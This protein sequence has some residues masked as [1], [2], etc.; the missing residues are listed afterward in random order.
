MKFIY[1]LLSKI[2]LS[3]DIGSVICALCGKGIAS[4]NAIAEI[5]DNETYTFDGS[6]CALIFK[7]YRT[8]YG[9]LFED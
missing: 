7:K 2:I 5:V 4:K 6:D 8:V 3:K 1:I 9:N